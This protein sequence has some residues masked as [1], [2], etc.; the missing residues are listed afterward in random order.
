[1]EDSESGRRN[2]GEMI[3]MKDFLQAN[4]VSNVAYI[5]A[6]GKAIKKVWIGKCWFAFR[7]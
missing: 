6:F 5:V 3:S 4:K 2:S 7:Q 1:M